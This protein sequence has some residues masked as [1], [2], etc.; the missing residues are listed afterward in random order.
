MIGPRRTKR[1]TESH[2]LMLR[3]CMDFCRDVERRW[4]KA[5]KAA[6]ADVIG[7]VARNR[8]NHCR[9]SPSGR[10]S[11]TAQRTCRSKCA[12]LD[13][14]YRRVGTNYIAYFT[15]LIVAGA[16]EGAYLFDALFNNGS[17]D[18]RS[19]ALVSCYRSASDSIPANSPR[20]WHRFI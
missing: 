1:Q 13:V 8:G 18:S 3:H 10:W 5:P 14:A 4:V 16:Y 2:V 7:G 6:G 9:K 19:A 15:H 12:P 11:S 20:A 17:E